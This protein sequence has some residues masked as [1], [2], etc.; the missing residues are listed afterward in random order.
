MSQ[1]G[2]FGR[3]SHLVY[4]EAFPPFAGAVFP[5]LQ[6]ALSLLRLVIY[7]FTILAKYRPVQNLFNITLSSIGNLRC[8]KLCQSLPYQVI[9]LSCLS[10]FYKYA[11][12]GKYL[13]HGAKNLTS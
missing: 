10:A 2:H 1:A 8:A 3:G 6:T 7:E 12:G 4:F 11:R 13:A 5:D 9:Y